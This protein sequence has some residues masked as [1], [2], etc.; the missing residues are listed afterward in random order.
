MTK[1]LKV[2]DSGVGPSTYLDSADRSSVFAY[3]AGLVVTISITDP[4]GGLIDLPVS[5]ILKNKM[6]LDAHDISIFR[7]LAGIPLY[8]SLFIGL[9][10]DRINKSGA[11]DRE[12]II[13]FS[14]CNIA[15][16]IA[17]SIFPV[18]YAS[19]LCASLFTTGCY[20]FTV[21]AQSGLM[22]SFAQ[23]H[24]VS[25]SISALWNTA[26]YLS[27]AFAFIGG[28]LISERLEGE[29]LDWSFQ[30][31]CYA[32]A[33]G[34]L[35]TAAF[36]YFQSK[37][38]IVRFNRDAMSSEPRASRRSDTQSIYPALI[39]WALWNFAPGS[40]TPLQFFLQNKLGAS[41]AQWG[42]WNATFTVSFLPAFILY[43]YLST[44]VLFQKLLFWSA[45]I[46]IPQFVPLLFI[47]SPDEAL[48][49]AVVAGLF[50]G[51]ATAAYLDLIIRS[52][53]PGLHGTA[54][55][56]AGTVY[57]ISTRLGDVFGTY[58]YETFGG[59]NACVFVMTAVYFT[60]LLVLRSVV[61]P[62]Q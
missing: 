2:L 8:L 11:W 56:A 17:L 51:M 22:A 43:G 18:T 28:G 1:P 44:K 41:D 61:H 57:F 38:V 36:A 59:F 9:L 49:F 40:V 54:M 7:L 37:T 10:R 42:T 58:L 46:A 5:F 48:I 21:S 34:S 31:I 39:I 19:M 12:M 13:G 24:S 45:M 3:F 62:P 4:S 33:F 53:P 30:V 16:Y 23:C 14:I 47:R 20:L 32:G 6:G 60:I 52:C 15:I 25:G 27:I 55:M 29:G 35:V 50:G 26:S